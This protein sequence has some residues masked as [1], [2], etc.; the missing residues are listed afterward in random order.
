MKTE[1]MILIGSIDPVVVVKKLKKIGQ[2]PRLETVGPAKEIEKK[3]DDAKKPEAKK[4]EGNK[5][6]VKKIE[7]MVEYMNAYNVRYP[8]YSQH[9]Y[10]R[11]VEEDPN[12]CVIS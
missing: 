7:P 3:K 6:E 12:A 8:Y 5:Q 9:Y 1:K 11:T 10:V 4:D 2:V